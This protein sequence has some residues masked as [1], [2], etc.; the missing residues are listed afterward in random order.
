M[1]S[2]FYNNTR[3]I[4]KTIITSR[5]TQNLFRQEYSALKSYSSSTIVVNYKNYIKNKIR[6]IGNSVL[7]NILLPDCN[8]TLR[9]F[10]WKHTDLTP[11]GAECDSIATVPMLFVFFHFWCNVCKVLSLRFVVFCVLN[12]EQLSLFKISWLYSI[13]FILCISTCIFYLC[14]LILIGN[15]INKMLP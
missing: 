13:P 15:S 4:V 5:M 6:S 7:H 11:G 12:F 8:L 2:I 1:K 3:N 9:V 14:V 10:R